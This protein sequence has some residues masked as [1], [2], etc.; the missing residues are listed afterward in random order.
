MGNE[1]NG[2]EAPQ[3]QDSAEQPVNPEQN[4]SE[5][6]LADS[7]YGA[8]DQDKQSQ[9]DSEVQDQDSQE[10]DKSDES[11]AVEDGA[12]EKYEFKFEEGFEVESDVLDA[13]S[14]VAKEANLNQEK[15]QKILETVLSKHGEI[16][17]QAFESKVEGWAEA[18]KVDKEFGGDK[19]Q[20][21]LAIAKKAF[22]DLGSPELLELMN[23][24][25]FGNHPEVIRLGYKIGKKLS[26]DT[27]VEGQGGKP[28]ARTGPSTD[29]EI[30]DALYGS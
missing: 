27:Y 23:E 15:A 14:E 16:Q 7:L 6:S 18:S 29:A 28:R 11:Q 2:S 9:Q 30:A 13:F 5:Q 21:N 17:A 4:L 1:L 10:G 22:T 12:P 20:E 26:E 3:T 24:T 8:E 25:G 19:L